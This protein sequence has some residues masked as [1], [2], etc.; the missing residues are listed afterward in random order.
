M[1]MMLFI[2]VISTLIMM[3]TELRSTRCVAQAYPFVYPQ[4]QLY[5]ERDHN[6]KLYQDGT[7]K[8]KMHLT[9]HSFGIRSG[10]R[11]KKPM[12][13]HIYCIMKRTR[14]QYHYNN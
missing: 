11:L 2:V 10:L 14:H 7:K 6:V 9:H 1:I 13:G 12:A 8:S 4:A 5:H 3:Y